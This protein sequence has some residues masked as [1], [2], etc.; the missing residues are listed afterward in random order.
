M[1]K[2]YF[3]FLFIRNEKPSESRAD[4][5]EQIQCTCLAKLVKSDILIHV[6]RAS[7]L[8][9][10]PSADLADHLFIFGL[11]QNKA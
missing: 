10:P 9:D 4:L 2:S 1:E 5:M 6:Y 7:F 8:S 11:K 3:S